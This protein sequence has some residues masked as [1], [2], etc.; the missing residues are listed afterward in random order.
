MTAVATSAEVTTPPA[1]HRAGLL[2]A[3]RGE[4]TKFWS[5]RSTPWSLAATALIVLGICVLATATRNAG[6]FANDPT[7]VSLFGFNFAQVAVGV[8]GTLVMSS[9]YS[10]GAIRST[11]SAMPRRP[12][13]LAAKVIVFG[14]V[15]AVVGEAL[16]FVTFFTG[17]AILSGIHDGAS[18][19]SPG[20]LR[21]VVTSGLYVVLVGLLA[22][23]LATM[24]RYTAATITAFI[25]ILLVIPLIIGAF[26]TGFQNAV[27]RY[28]PATI[29]AVSF[30]AFPPARLNNTPLLGPWVGLGVLALYAIVSL[31]AG[32]F[33]MARR[34][35]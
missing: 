26:P 8:L 17:Q 5:V 18:I 12:V 19:G 24:I 30:S 33:L 7:R 32:G 1:G 34:D 28:L 11:L 16:S 23:G 22:L 29:G 31:V 25:A 3:T 15:I 10:T 21:A 9:E 4:W 2:Q 13:V 20:A 6:D 35:S 14:A 27:D